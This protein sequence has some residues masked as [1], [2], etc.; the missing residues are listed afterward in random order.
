[1]R[2]S[3]RCKFTKL[4]RFILK[5]RPFTEFYLQLVLQ[6]NRT[7]NHLPVQ[8]IQCLICARLQEFDFMFC[9]FLMF[10]LQS[11]VNNI[12]PV[13]KQFLYPVADPGGPGTLPLLKLF[14]KKDGN[15]T[16]PQVSRVIAPPPG[17]ISGS[18]TVACQTLLAHDRFDCQKQGQQA[19]ITTSFTL[20]ISR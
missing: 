7:E 3:S 17:Q 18:A 8:G 14:K 16:A 13:D 2:L 10:S 15:R 4:F 20:R 9:S 11:A 5:T 6:Y 12:L 1:M 19:L